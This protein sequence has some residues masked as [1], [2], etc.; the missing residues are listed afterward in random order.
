MVTSIAEG[1]A[2]VD[3]ANIAIV[4]NATITL[5]FCVVFCF[6]RTIYLLKCHTAALLVFQFFV[7]VILSSE[8]GFGFPLPVVL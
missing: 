8:R 1:I 5:L 7:V 2:T 4:I 3:M 6:K